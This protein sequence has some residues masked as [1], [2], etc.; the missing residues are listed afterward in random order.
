MVK[1]LLD[2]GHGGRDPGSIG[3]N[4]QE[5]DINLSVA[6]KIGKILKRHSVKVFYSRTTDVFVDLGDRV[7]MANNANVDIL[8]SIHCN[9]FDNP[10]AQGVETFS[11]TSSVKGSELAKS[12]Q[13]SLIRDKLYT[14]NR[15]IKTANFAVLR[16]TKIPASLVELAFISNDEDANILRNKQSEL[17]ESVA[18]GILKYMGITYVEN[19]E[20]DTPSP[21][22]KEA[23][24]WAKEK[25]IIDGTRPRDNTTREEIIAMIYRARR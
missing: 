21:W 2:P 25:G 10:L 23:W 22:A 1:V 13:E 20:I 4:L 16:L 18:K 19:N 17:A 5:K 12:I 9:S 7:I 6:L 15:G 3:N 14:K 11:H 24:E 8:V